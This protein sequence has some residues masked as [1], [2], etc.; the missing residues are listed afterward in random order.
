MELSELTAYAEE[1]YHIQELHK[2]ADFPGFSVLVHPHTGK[3]VAL[4]MRQWDTDSGVE[5]QRCDVKCGREGLKELAAPYLSQP[6]R[7][8]GEKWVG[9]AFDAR[10]EPEVVFR[11]FDRAVGAAS[12][13]DGRGFTIVLEEKPT[14]LKM[15]HV[16]PPTDAAAMHVETALP[17]EVWRTA[18]TEAAVP[19]KICAMMARYDYGTPSDGSASR[20]NTFT[21]KCRNFYRQ[22]TFMADYEDDM[23]YT[24]A[25]KQ[26][27]PTYHDLNVKQL[28][29]YFTWRTHVRKGEYLPI[30]TSLAYLYLYEL[31][32]GIGTDSPRD[33][34]AKM[35]AFE[36]GYIDSGIGDPAM[37]KNLHRWRFEFAVIH[38][39]PPE[40]ARAYADPELLAQDA[41]L[42]VLRAPDAETDEAVFAALEYFVGKKLSQSAVLKKDAARGKRLFAAVWRC[43]SELYP[44][45]GAGAQNGRNLFTACFGKKHTRLWHPLANAIYWEETPHADC[46]Y[47]LD[48]CR[49]YRC[50]GGIWRQTCYD[51]LYFDRKTLHGLMHEAD[52]QLRLFL[53]C[54]HPLKEKPDDAWAAPY[55]RAVIRGEMWAEE[56]A[57]RPQVALDLSQLAQ[58]RE[59]ARHTRDSLLTE[60][61]LAEMAAEAVSV[62]AAPQPAPSFAEDGPL[63]ALD[64][65]H[66]QI[67]AALVQGEDACALVQRHHLMPSVVADTINEALFDAIGD[68]VLESDGQ[69]LVLVEDYRDDLIEMMGGYR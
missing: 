9:V 15:I 65:L 13:G 49:T 36:K 64:A 43:A 24:G 17:P 46:V 66:R 52:R 33:A 68:N 48:A 28:R 44:T 42:A 12:L 58:I 59:D 2:W 38:D 19:E 54:G 16:A 41:T 14:P 56:A 61:E 67:L 4:L 26:Y 31:L 27:V 18:A 6:F 22:G 34:L 21:R 51:G 53:K 35:Q 32:C 40:E 3:W 62:E 37:R 10:T 69:G 57:R 45:L 29:G 7:M 39:L 30:A 55:V 1:K 11:L 5:I 47:A 20:E 25:Y 60:E 50:R 63:A 8:N 23:P